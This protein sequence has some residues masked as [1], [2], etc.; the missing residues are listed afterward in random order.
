MLSVEYVKSLIERHQK[1]AA[2]HIERLKAEIKNNG[3]ND[4]VRDEDVALYWSHPDV[5]YSPLNSFDFI[6]YYLKCV[7][8]PG[9]PRLH[10]RIAVGQRQRVPRFRQ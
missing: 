2:D 5:L 7:H 3:V 4:W 10:Q 8:V 9:Q 1:K 6:N